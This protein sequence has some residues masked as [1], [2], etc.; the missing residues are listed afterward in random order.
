MDW[1]KVQYQLGQT[2]RAIADLDKTIRTLTVM[3]GGACVLSTLGV[4]MAVSS[5]LQNQYGSAALIG[6]GAVAG[7]CVGVNGL[8]AARRLRDRRDELRQQYA[9]LKKIR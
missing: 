4:A 7:A 6:G 9:Q 8:L 2:Q 1:G 5:V 3:G